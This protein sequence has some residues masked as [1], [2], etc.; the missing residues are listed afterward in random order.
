MLQ[1]ERLFERKKG[2]EKEGLKK[3]KNVPPFYMSGVASSLQEP[4]PK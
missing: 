1:L 4:E 2:K 3:E